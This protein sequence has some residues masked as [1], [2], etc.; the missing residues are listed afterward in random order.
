MRCGECEGQ[1][2]YRTDP[3]P[4][5]PCGRRSWQRCYGCNG[6]GEELFDCR[7]CGQPGAGYRAH[8]GH[9]YCSDVCE[10]EQLERDGVLKDE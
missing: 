7:F 4:L 6:T 10:Y 2:S 1:G 8:D 5:D 3:H 9:D